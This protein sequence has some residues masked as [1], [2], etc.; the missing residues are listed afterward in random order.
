MLS[1][2]TSGRQCCLYTLNLLHLTGSFGHKGTWEDCKQKNVC[3]LTIHTLRYWWI[4]NTQL[5]GQVCCLRGWR[6]EENTL[7]AMSS[8]QC[9]NKDPSWNWRGVLVPWPLSIKRVMWG[10][11]TKRW[12]AQGQE[13]AGSDPCAWLLPS[14]SPITVT[15]FRCCPLLAC[16]WFWFLL[17]WKI[18]R[19]C[20]KF[21]NSPLQT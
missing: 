3:T 6:S 20:A 10:T 11:W 7:A 19:L 17:I 5:A 12:T 1:W 2:S 21:W 8:K 18:Q 13:K 16:F 4:I 14:C 15:A 9:G